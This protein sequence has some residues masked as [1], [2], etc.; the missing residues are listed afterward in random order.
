MALL[1]N[2]YVYYKKHIFDKEIGHPILLSVII[3]LYFLIDHQNT[4]QNYII[5]G[6]GS[7]STFSFDHRTMA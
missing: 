5:Y 3:V 7:I 4:S 2:L 6:N 1:L